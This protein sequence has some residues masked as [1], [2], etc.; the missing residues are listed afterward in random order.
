M[1]PNNESSTIIIAGSGVLELYVE[2]KF[3]FSGSSSLN[4]KGEVGQVMVYY[5]GDNC[6]LYTSRCV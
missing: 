4:Y 2:N 6:L 1:P 5:K 3:T